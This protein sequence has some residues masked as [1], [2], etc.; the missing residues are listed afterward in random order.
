MFICILHLLALV[1]SYFVFRE[2][3]LLFIV[4]E[5]VILVSIILSRQLYLEMIRPLKLLMEGANAIRDRDFAV[6]FRTTGKYEMDQLIDV[7][8]QMIDELRAERTRQEEQ[9]LFLEKLIFTSPTGILILDH[10]EKVHQVNPRALEYLGLQEKELLGRAIESID[11]PV[12]R[13]VSH[14]RSGQA[15][16]VPFNGSLTFKLQ[17]S[18][19][20]DRG[21]PRHFI[22]IEELSSEILAAEKLVY[23]KVIRM[24]AHDVNNTI[25]PVNS[26]L[27]STLQA[28]DHSEILADALRVAMERNNNLNQFMRNFADLVRISMPVKKP[29]DLVKLSEDMVAFM[30]YR[31]GEKK[32]L[33]RTE[34]SGA[35]LM[36]AADVQQMEQVLINILKNSL[37]AI[38]EEG[39]I[40][41]TTHS[42]P[43][44]LVICDTGGGIAASSEE[45]LFSPFYS[46]K[47][48][49]QGIGLTIIREI[50][51]NH[52]FHFSLRTVSPG[53]TEFVIYF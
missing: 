43:K 45:F 53:R 9:H 52:G 37:E 50:L 24:M 10:D 16:T 4:S 36:I 41:V 47:K 26:I 18:H 42:H 22:M 3:I 20:I 40:T 27:Q 21:F 39:G 5:I 30:R 11:H 15:K 12:I 51:L 8:N 14:L 33:F 6:K 19:F 31:T 1:L 7:Y 25:G 44:K 28:Q 32:I 2:Y 48:D 13:Q 46:T 38:D 34:H 17:R 29:M 23:G 49:G 35:A